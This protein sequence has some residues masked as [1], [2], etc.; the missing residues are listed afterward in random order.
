[1]M[2]GHY[3]NP[4]FVNKKIKIRRPEHSLTPSPTPPPST[5]LCPITSHF[6]LNPP[7]HLK[8]SAICVSPLN[9]INDFLAK[10]TTRFHSWAFFVLDI[11]QLLTK[12][13]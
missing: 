3:T 6:C 1:M 11:R 12:W 7:P 2:S 8:M 10:S 5:S 9:I 13:P 4:I